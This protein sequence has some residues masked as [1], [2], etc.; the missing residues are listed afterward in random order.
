MLPGGRPGPLFLSLES[1]LELTGL[2]LGMIGAVGLTS[3]DEVVVVPP[4]VLVIGAV[5]LLESDF[6][7]FR[8]ERIQK[9]KMQ[10]SC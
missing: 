5:L 3:N 1:F 4:L 8:P 6:F 7:R 9:E 2:L 10:M